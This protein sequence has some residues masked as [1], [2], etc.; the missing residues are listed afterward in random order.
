[1][2]KEGAIAKAEQILKRHSGT[3]WADGEGSYC[4]LA[5]IDSEGYPSASTITA[6]KADGLKQI[7]FCTG[8]SSNKAARIKNCDR[9]SVCFSGPDYNITLVGTIEVLTSP[10]IKKEMWYEPLAHHFSGP[11]DPQYC[12]LRLTPNRYNLLIDWQEIAGTI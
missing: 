1:M 6:S 4:T 5:L 9:A 10:E 7:F 8:L 11:D 12:V 2:N 3:S